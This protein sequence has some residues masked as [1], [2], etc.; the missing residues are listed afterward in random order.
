MAS[1]GVNEDVDPTLPGLYEYS[2][3]GVG[4]GAIL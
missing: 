2:D 4:L 1:F 3:A